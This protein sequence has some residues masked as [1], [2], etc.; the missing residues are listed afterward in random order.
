MIFSLFD[1]TLVIGVWKK[2]ILETKNRKQEERELIF[3]RN[4]ERKIK[5]KGI[6]IYGIFTLYNNRYYYYS[7]CQLKDL[8]LTLFGLIFGRM[9]VYF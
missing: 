9:H 5:W 8:I 6:N 7:M 3:V 1:F 2:N 4:E